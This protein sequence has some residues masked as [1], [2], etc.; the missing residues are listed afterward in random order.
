M[1]I[2]EFW[3]DVRE[4]REGCTP[5]PTDTG[6]RWVPNDQIPQGLREE[7]PRWVA[8][9]GGHIYGIVVAATIECA[10]QIAWESWH[11]HRMTVRPAGRGECPLV[12]ALRP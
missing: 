10:R 5:I 12:C 11:V 8:E 3:Q 9:C 1:T 2:E 7:W 6:I 4:S